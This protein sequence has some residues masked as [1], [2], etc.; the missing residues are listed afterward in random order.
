MTTNSFWV[1]WH[2]GKHYTGQASFGL[3]E[4]ETQEEAEKAAQELLKFDPKGEVILL[5]GRQILRQ[6]NLRP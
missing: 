2:L 5:E 3:D 1:Y 4:Y 6:S